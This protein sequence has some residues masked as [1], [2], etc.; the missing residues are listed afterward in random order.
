MISIT[1]LSQRWGVPYKRLSR[2]VREFNAGQKVGW[3]VVLTEEEAEKL[4]TSLENKRLLRTGKPGHPILLGDKNN[5]NKKA[6]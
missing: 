3:A 4:R 6:A 2:W 1:E 5:G